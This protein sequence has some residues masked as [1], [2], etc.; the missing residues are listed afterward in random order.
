MN[1]RKRLIRADLRNITPCNSNEIR[2]LN[3]EIRSYFASIKI[4]NVRRV[5]SGG[6][7]NL[8]KAVKFAKNLVTNELPSNL[9]LGGNP[10]AGCDVANSFDKHFNLSLL[11]LHLSGI[12]GLKTGTST[13]SCQLL[14]SRLYIHTTIKIINA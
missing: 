7:T 13:P 11:T 14:D 4:G 8:W 3:Y 9:T 1:R 5:A 2:L 12:P 6:G 10:V